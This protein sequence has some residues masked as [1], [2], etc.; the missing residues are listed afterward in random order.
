MAIVPLLASPVFAATMK[1]TL[2]LPE[3]ELPL[4]IEIHAAEGV[5]VQVHAG[6]LAVSAIVPV[7]PAEGTGALAGEIEYVQGGGGAAWLSVNVWPA[8][9]TVAVRCSP[10][11]ASTFSVTV[12]VPVAVAPLPTPTH[13]SLLTA[14]H[15]H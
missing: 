9:A 5:A 14:V 8:S 1:A 10:V 4:E 6:S 11:L 13:G 12:P 7:P 2:P 3:P 15:E